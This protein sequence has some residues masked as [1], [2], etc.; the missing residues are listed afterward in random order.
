M[1]RVDFSRNVLCHSNNDD[2]FVVVCARDVFT[3]GNHIC[4]VNEL[5][6]LGAADKQQTIGKIKFIGQYH[7]HLTQTMDL[8]SCC[9]SFQVGE[10][11]P[12]S[13]CDRKILPTHATL[14]PFHSATHRWCA[15]RLLSIHRARNWWIQKLCMGQRSVS[16]VLS[17]A[18]T[19]YT[20]Q[21]QSDDQWSKRI[22]D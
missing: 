17:D 21:C 2:S 13:F 6:V 8:V 15:W 9:C 16:D 4:D 1:G 10:L 5:H 3:L 7:G 19:N 20:L 18:D 22:T 11:W 12:R 14:F